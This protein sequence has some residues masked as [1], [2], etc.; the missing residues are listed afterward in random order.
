MPAARPHRR[1][2]TPDAGGGS[3]IWSA[4]RTMVTSGPEAI[5][6]RLR[7]EAMRDAVIVEAVRTPVGKRNG[8]LSTMHPGDL[9]AVALGGPV[10]RARGGPRRVGGVIWGGVSQIG[11][12][13]SSTARLA[14]PPAGAP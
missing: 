1:R 3:W 8:G 9:S 5:G 7:E 10:R 11:A 14:S 2:E 12:R 4:S 13:P 6:P